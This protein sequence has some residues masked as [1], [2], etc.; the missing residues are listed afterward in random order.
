MVTHNTSTGIASFGDA[1]S[2]ELKSNKKYMLLVGVVSFII[3]ISLFFASSNP[4]AMTVPME[5]TS[6]NFDSNGRYILENYDSLKPMANFLCGIGGLWGVPMWAF[7][8]NRGQGITS[9]GINNKDG[10]IAKF[11]TAEKAYQQTPFTGFRTFVKGTKSDGTT[12]ASMPFFPKRGSISMSKNDDLISRNMMIGTNEMEIQEIDSVNDLQTNVLYYTIPNEDFPSLVRKTTFTNLDE[13][14]SIDIEVLDGLGRLVPSGLGNWALDAMGR[15]MEAWMNVYNVNGLEKNEPFF[16]ISQGTADSAQVQIIKDGHFSVAFVDDD[17]A[18]NLD[19]NGLYKQLPFIVDPSVVFDTDTTLTDPRGFF[20]SSDSIHDILALPQGTTS[21]TPC[22]FAGAKLHIEPGKSVSIITVYGHSDNVD[23]FVGVHSPLLRRSGYVN[24]KREEAEALANGITDKVATKT[25]SSVFDAYVKQ[26]FLDNVLRGGLPIALGDSS[27]PKIYHTFSRIHGDIERDY[28]NFQIDTTYFSQG[29]GNFRDVN[30]NR[31]LDV[32]HTPVV[33]DFNI[34]MFLSFVQADAY[35]PLTVATTNFK[36]PASKIELLV[37]SLHVKEDYPGR[38]NS[39]LVA[40]LLRRPFRIGQLFNDFKTYSLTFDIEKSKVVD[41]IVSH[42]N[43]EV[44]AQYA[45]NGFWADHWTYTLDLVE[46]YLTVFPDKESSLLFESAPVPFYMSPAVVRPRHTRY[47]LVASPADPSKSTIR[48]YN[49]VSAWGDKDFPTTRVNAL[50][51][52]YSDPS[53]VADTAG[54]GGV[55]QRTKSGDVFA[56][57]IITKLAMLGI[58]K[59]STLDPNGMGV[60]MEGGKPGWNDAMNGLP[61][62]LG[63]GMPETYEMLRV[64]RFVKAAVLKH[65]GNIQFP[66]EFYTFIEAL[67]AASTTY[68]SSSKTAKDNVAYWDAC[69]TARETYRDSTVAT[70]DG[71]FSSFSANE[72]VQIISKME[73]KTEDGIARALATNN[74]LSP[75]YFHYECT[76]YSIID[77]VITDPTGPAPPTQIIAKSFDLRTLPLF[78]EGPTRHMKVVSSIEE[79]RNIYNLAKESKLYD[80][81][82][83]MFTISESLIGM[84][85]DVGRMMAFSP[86]WLENQSVWLHMSYKFYLELLRGGL[87]DEFYTEIKT[88]L[89]PFMDNEVYGRSPLEAASFIVSSAFPDKKLHGASFLARLSGSTAEFLSMWA[90]MFGGDQPFTVNSDNELVCQLQP[91]LHASFFT[92]ENTVSFTFLGEINVTYYNPERKN[93]WDATP[94]KASVVMKDGTVVAVNDAIF[95][96]DLAHKI[97]NLEVK[98]IKV[99]Y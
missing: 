73:M 50:N 34:R 54:A 53:Y 25:S 11:N 3:I 66:T 38:S 67:E 78:L 81:A 83:Q 32:L 63:S 51:T 60:E 16:H 72:F 64:L 55:W 13:H 57:P 48:V 28:N 75:T 22:A 77:P 7:Y 94:Q 82:L 5:A 88:G 10:A 6:A 19:S 85:Q 39:A 70:F 1:V 80:S 17:S 42:A 41:I 97:R 12:F 65:N 86:G 91:K 9:F 43:Q 36:I 37:P 30:Q 20:A 47:S 74:G 61:G 69:N 56:V 33:G 99:Y 49:A 96:G 26:D 15:T 87:Y 27:N 45:Q 84:G 21:R 23:Q 35:N 44:A 29:P 46:N 40:S 31:R 4:A 24:H 79:R 8:V 89:V 92:V 76:D 68:A 2:S 18:G 95:V 58:L 59:F 14:S 52:I 62:I 98:E 90:I 93:T 71:S